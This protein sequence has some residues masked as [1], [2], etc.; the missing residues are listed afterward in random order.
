VFFKGSR[1]ERVGTA[2]LIDE[3]SREVRYKLMRA[4]PQPEV[5]YGYAVAA[6]D[7]LD[8]I[9]FE[10]FRD[11]ERFWRIC[12]TNVVMWP[13]ELAERPG[14]VIAIPGPAPEG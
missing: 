1:Y 11:A 13:P 8:N 10:V 2:V 9:A 7:R 5:R 6:G 4:L 14:W 12:D 3:Q